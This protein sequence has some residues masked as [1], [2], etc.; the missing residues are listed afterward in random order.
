[1]LCISIIAFIFILEYHVK[2]HMDKTCASDERR[3]IFGGRVI[4][5]KHYNTGIAG[6]FLSGH[7]KA[8]RY[9]HSAAFGAAAGALKAFMEKKGAAALK[10]GLAFLIG[11]G[12]S[13]LFDRLA[14]GH[15]VDYFSFGFGSKKFR[16]LVFNI[17]DMF[18]AAGMIL[19]AA[20]ILKRKKQRK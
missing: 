5:K 10:L 9:L 11:G 17:A 8:V 19:C 20:G 13:N 12:L 7:P 16:R 18:I 6:N 14:K 4:L 1:M 2:K 3:P 15:V